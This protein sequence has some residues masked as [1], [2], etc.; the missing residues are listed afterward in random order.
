M[1]SLQVNVWVSIV[2]DGE[3][4]IFEKLGHVI[5]CVSVGTVE[6]VVRLAINLV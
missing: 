2:F 1:G 4:D 3:A 5:K 6:K